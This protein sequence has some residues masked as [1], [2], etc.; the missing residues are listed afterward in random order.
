MEQ[1]GGRA[2]GRGRA[3][4]RAQPQP[5]QQQGPPPQEQ[6]QPK[7]PGEQRGQQHRGPPP[8]PQ[9]Q[10]QRGP[11]R[12]QQEQVPQ[13]SGAGRVAHRGGGGG[14]GAAFLQ[15]KVQEMSLSGS[16]REAGGGDNGGRG[17]MRGRRMIGGAIEAFHTRPGHISVK[18]GKTGEP[19]M[20]TANYFP[21]VTKTDW[22]LYQYRVDFSPEED[23]TPVKKALLNVQRN[24]IAVPFIFDGSMMFTSHR[25]S[26]DPMEHFSK[27]DSD[28]QEIRITIKLVGDLHPGD[29]HYLQF[30]NILTRKILGQ[31]DLKLVGTKFLDPANKSEVREFNMEIWPGILTTTSQH[32]NQILMCVELVHKYL[33]KDTVLDVFRDVC[34]KVRDRDRYK[35]VFSTTIIGSIVMTEYNNKTYRVDDVRYDLRPDS[36]F[37]KKSGG[38]ISFMQYYKERYD[39]T[40]RTVEQPLLVYRSKKREMKAGMPPV[41]LLIPE[42]CKM[43]GLTD[44]MRSNFNLMRALASHTCLGPALRIKKTMEYQQKMT[45]TPVAAQELKQW[46]VQLG[47]D[48]VRF[49]A[50]I[51]QRETI[52]LGNEVNYPVGP[53]A[54]WTKSFRNNSMYTKGHLSKW[55]C[56]CPRQFMRDAEGFIA[57]LRKVASGMKMQMEHPHCEELHQDNTSAYLEKLEQVMRNYSPEFILCVVPNNRADRYSGIKKKCTADR[58]VPT[59]VIV[60][61]KMQGSN[62]SIATKVAIQINCKIGGSPWTVQVP[63]SGLMVVGFDVCHDSKNK[64]RSY[65]ALVASLNKQLT[66]YYSAVSSH[67]T[68]EELSNDISLNVIKAI[69][70]YQ[71]VNKALPDKIIV[72]R[73]GV[74]DG[75]IPYV[76]DYELNALLTALKELY[77]EPPKLAFIIV[78]KRI[79][80]RLFL[81][82]N[83]PPPGTVVDNCITRPERYDFFLIS[84]SVRQ[85]TVSPTSYN[86]I[87]DTL[88]LDPDKIQRLTYKLTH[89]YFNWSGTVAVPA[90]CQYAH[91][92]AFLVAQALHIPPN[93]GLED[94]LFFL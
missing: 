57:A 10:Q 66:R 21:F 53:D 86:V 54:D 89:M 49:P 15:Q 93:A 42:L 69:K 18:Q 85:G 36:T 90:P 33:R 3:R 26:P 55:V 82:Q 20:L 83:N 46:N 22:C 78:T 1:Q 30:F 52:I 16:R 17:A 80:T 35:E 73:D 50:R 59:Q 64:Q 23:R 81:D 38:S 75:Q 79:G 34:Q 94:L 6:Q 61:K 14:E 27:R 12:Q 24:N 31:L 41:V 45:A 67:A 84:Q 63:L 91:K 51:V 48:L 8:T 19:I 71:T 76:H 47:R 56:I 5:T 11:P 62:L 65:G 40:I 87:H 37:D 7:R 43:T 13:T 72:Y 88:G 92:L 32:E 68:G 44:E 77:N 2:R 25:L 39:I 60:A 58:A 9:Q 29:Y 74:G 28:N 70:K 4:A